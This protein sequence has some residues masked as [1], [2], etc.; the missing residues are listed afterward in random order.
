MMRRLATGGFPMVALFLLL[1]CSLWLL[2]STAESFERFGKLYLWLLLLNAI[3]LAFIASLVVYNSWSVIQQFRRGAA[4]SRLT[5]KLVLMFVVLSLTPVSIVYS[6]SVRFI[7]SGIDSWFDDQLERALTDALDLSREGLASQQRAFVAGTARVAKVLVGL[8]AET[9][10]LALNDLREQVGAGELML[11]SDRSELVATSAG[12]E[13]VG[14]EFDP[15]DE[16]ILAQVRQ[17]ETYVGLDVI[18]ERGSRIRVVTAVAS[19]DPSQDPQILQALYPVDEQTRAQVDS[20]ESAFGYYK[21]LT[22]LRGPIKTLYIMTL[23][24]ALLLSVLTAVWAGF[25]AARR[26]MAP[27]QDLAAGTQAV[28]DGDYST[29]LPTSGKDELGFL[30]QSF[31]Q[32][33]RRLAQ[34]RDAADNSQRE[35][36]NQRSYLQ[37]VLTTVSAGVLT[38]DENQA[39]RTANA[40]AEEILAM[41]LTSQ[42]GR[43]LVDLADRYPVFGTLHERLGS[44]L[45]RSDGEWR[46][47]LEIF[48]RE[49]RRILLC[50]VSPLPH[51]ATAQAGHVIVFDDITLLLQAQRDA[52][53][54]EV[55]RRLAHEIK[56]PLTPIQLSAERLR[57]KYL[58]KL[59]K[60]ESLVLERATHTIVQQVEAMK[61]MVKAFADY[62]RTPEI[63]L[64]A[65]EINEVIQ[66]VVE[67][68]RGVR[69]EMALE[70]RLDDNLPTMLA[71]RA[72]LRQV[73]HN[74]IKNA[75][76]AQAEQAEPGIE[77]Y[78]QQTLDRGAHYIEVRVR[79]AGAGIPEDLLERLFE[80]YVS[81]KLKGSGLGLAIVKKIVEEHSGVVFAENPPSGGAQLTVR[82]PLRDVMAGQR[83]NAA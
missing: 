15:P 67:L 12:G 30:V 38:F 42:L 60:E 73:L 28:A 13:Q 74:L 64:E 22:F 44:V 24:L 75:L 18:G 41:S 11:L 6:F 65:V 16:V 80:P 34:A 47:E 19:N 46:G 62:A 29:Q 53:W 7:E 77:V 21:Q 26:L 61:T 4:G 82:L 81:S 48:G 78:S 72:R 57:Q 52:A 71:D 39:L 55:A 5:A 51:P 49:G 8:P 14:L 32:M 54:G 27:V 76:E 10:V 59:P 31:N 40:A 58:G 35:V 45:A 17:G 9:A 68:Y 37:T 25:F 33:T 3:G 20:V 69:P 23:S 56:N 79:D 1:L 2:G 83:G 43:C 63:S 66:E 70:L 50:R 36:E